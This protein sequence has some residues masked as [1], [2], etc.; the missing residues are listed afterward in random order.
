[1]AACGKLRD[2]PKPTSCK[3]HRLHAT[4]RRSATT[5]FAAAEAAEREWLDAARDVPATSVP[6]STGR[7]W[8]KWDDLAGLS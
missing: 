5:C 8:Q 6:S 2:D 7:A 3:A 1:M 4:A